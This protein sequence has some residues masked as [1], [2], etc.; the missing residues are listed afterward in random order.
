MTSDR[1]AEASTTCVIVAFHRPAWLAGLLGSLR[2]PR[3]EVIVVNVEDDAGIRSL[4]GA[5]HTIATTTNLGYAAGVNIGAAMATGEVTVFMNDDLE[6]T[7]DDVVALSRRIRSNAADVTVP[8]VIDSTGRLELQ[9]RIPFRLAE[10]MLLHGERVPTVPTA[11]DAAWASIVAV[12]TDL[13]RAVPIPE[14]Y[15]LYWE[16]FE[17][18]HRLRA[19]GCRVEVLPDVCVRHLGGTQV[20]RR[21]RSRLMARN[22][23]RCVRRTRGRAAALRAWPEVILWQAHLLLAS[24]VHRK[25]RRVVGAHAAGLSAALAAWREI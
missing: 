19:R 16:E 18:F 8:M 17:W 11:V 23:V 15:F 21:Q 24:L 5:A 1:T 20:V 7:A 9:D 14:V 22:A 2:D 13:L 4:P 25:E 6:V 12:R 3:L 10:K